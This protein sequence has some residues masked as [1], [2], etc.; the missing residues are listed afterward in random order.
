MKQALGTPPR[1][2]GKT[3]AELVVAKHTTKNPVT[4]SVYR[5]II[6]KRIYREV[7]M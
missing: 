7:A 3:L 6:D 2:R 4:R 1:T 5:D